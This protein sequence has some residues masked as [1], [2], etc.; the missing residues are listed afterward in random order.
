MASAAP[1]SAQ[2][3]LSTH[4]PPDVPPS[5]TAID[6]PL[7]ASP[8]RAAAEGL[9][10]SHE[11][12]TTAVMQIGATRVALKSK[13]L[14]ITVDGSFPKYHA[15]SRCIIICLSLIHISEPTRPY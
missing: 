15:C 13:V 8:D 5:G 2:S 7:A 10:D 11:S 12:N 14:P 6:A 1:E 9:L 4:A 3:A